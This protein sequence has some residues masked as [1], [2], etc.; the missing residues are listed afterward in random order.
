MGKRSS[1][2]RMKNDAYDTPVEAVLPLI[3]HLPDRFTFDEPCAGCGQLADALKNFGGVPLSLFDIEPRRRDVRQLDAFNIADTGA[4][5]IIT[6]P[7]WTRELL[8]PLILHLC[9]LAPTWLLLDAGWAFTKRAAPYMDHCR[10]VVAV[11]RLRWIPGS[12]HTGKDD[13]AWY[14]FTHATDEPTLFFHRAE[15]AE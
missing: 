10:K 14:L 11:G 15:A 1:F 2:R 6:N 4:Q 5:Y 13:C 8:H 9:Q 7:P 3:S 12:P